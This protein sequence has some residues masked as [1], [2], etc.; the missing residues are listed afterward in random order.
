MEVFA[1]GETRWNRGFGQEVEDETV[2]H[3]LCNSSEELD[4]LCEDGLLELPL[5]VAI[6]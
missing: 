4:D 3:G 5:A 6:A 1:G 2:G